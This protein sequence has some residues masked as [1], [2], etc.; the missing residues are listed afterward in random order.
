MK[1]AVQISGLIYTPFDSYYTF[2]QCL[3]NLFDCDIF[4][5]STSNIKEI[6]LFNPLDY[7]HVSS[8]DYI[9]SG[10]NLLIDKYSSK[11]YKHKNGFQYHSNCESIFK[12]LYQKYLCD[13][14][15]IKSEI[16]Y[17]VVVWLRGDLMLAEPFTQSI[18]NNTTNK[19]LIPHCDDWHGGINDQICLGDPYQMSRMCSQILYLD[20]YFRDPSL[21]IHPERLLLHHILLQKIP[22]RKFSYTYYIRGRMQCAYH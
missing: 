17:D 7:S 18:I 19:I 9:D 14:L 10:V 16:K 4:V 12:A 15:R 11:Y 13:Q 5:A 2:R 21:T 1:I 22:V 8:E 20:E 6:Q 3:L